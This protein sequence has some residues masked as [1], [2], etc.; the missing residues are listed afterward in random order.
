MNWELAGILLALGLVVFGVSIRLARSSGGLK[1]EN[2]GLKLAARKTK[3]AGKV[4]GRVWATGRALVRLKLPD[5]PD[6]DA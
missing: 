4:A 2:K 3:A 5:D 1:R 6:R